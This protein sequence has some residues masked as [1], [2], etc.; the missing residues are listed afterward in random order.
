MKRLICAL[1]VLAMLLPLSGC[2]GDLI[3]GLKPTEVPATE[4][5]TAAPTPSPTEAPTEAPTEEPTPEPTPDPEAANNAFRELDLEIF[6][7]LVTSGTDA[8]HQY[9]VDDPAAFG[10]DPDDVI[11]GWGDLT[12]QAHVSSME[13]YREVIASL[14]EIDYDQLS[15]MNKRGY[16]AIKRAC[17]KELAF[18]NYYYYDEPLEPINGIQT[19]LPLSMTCFTIRNAE[20]IETYLCL[21]E[22]MPRF[23]GQIEQFEIDKARQGLFMTET[24]LDDV[25]ESIES[26]TKKGKKSVLITYF[27][28]EII[29]KA[30]EFG[31]TD[32]ECDA[33]KERNR[34]AVMDGVL[35]AYTHLKETLEAH[36]GDCGRFLG[37]CSKTE[38]AYNYYLLKLQYEG[39][40]MDDP[41][42]IVGLLED[43]GDSTYIELFKAITYGPSDLLDQFGDPLT[44]G[45]LEDNLAWLEEFI[46]KYYPDLPEYSL[47]Y[48]QVPDDLAD[49]FSPAAYLTPAFDNYYDNLMLVNPSSEGA[50]DLL[51]VAHETVP[52][53]MFQFLYARN[54]E[55]LSLAQQLFEPTGY[56]EGWTVFTEYF[57]ASNCYEINNYLCILT[58]TNST[59]CN[60]FLPA[61]V[62]VLVNL[63]GYDKNEVNKFLEQF[64]MG[65]AS[66][67]LYEYA[68]TM[69]FYA[70]NYAIGYA[71]MLAI[72]QDA[73]PKGAGEHKRFFEKYLS[74]GPCDM[75]MMR[76]YMK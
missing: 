59:F 14:E 12:Y 51:T 67:I 53:H 35:P 63:Y 36:R 10:I 8:Y 31:M 45:S 41:E 74:F 30:K 2:L 6:R 37:A 62:S 55:G 38:M 1:L 23:I 29:A 70:M 73:A 25:I 18:E 58:N 44:L 69:P 9:I 22:D 21:V 11:P 34:T 68:I 13:Y 7:T 50:D 15:D 42:T 5:P 57:V 32:E 48:Q 54:M 4:I 19:M 28:S 20:D 56:A 49:S 75:D 26:I 71:Y 39:A 61:Y 43:M 24:A 72:Y 52:G 47:T 60:I 66:D 40:T 33:L 27:N 64:G 46:K 3:P 16:D 17:E 76:E 65:S